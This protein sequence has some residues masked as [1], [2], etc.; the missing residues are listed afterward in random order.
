MFFFVASQEESRDA[1]IDNG[2]LGHTSPDS[3]FVIR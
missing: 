1:K 2:I 3:D